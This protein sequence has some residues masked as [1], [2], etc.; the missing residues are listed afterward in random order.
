MGELTVTMYITNTYQCFSKDK[1]VSLLYWEIVFRLQSLLYPIIF[2]KLLSLYLNL[3]ICEPDRK[4][5]KKK[6]N[7]SLFLICELK[8]T[9]CWQV[10]REVGVESK[11]GKNT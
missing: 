10:L 9:R 4:E 7:Y 1:T 5:K 2:R 6:Q 3:P 11:Q 8:W